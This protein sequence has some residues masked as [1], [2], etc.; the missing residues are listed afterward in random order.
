MMLELKNIS[1][2][3]SDF[4]LEDVSFQLGNSEYHMLLGPSGAGK[5]LVM[6]IIA[7]FQKPDSGNILYLSQDITNTEPRSRR[8]SY[9]IQDLALFPHLTVWENVA[10]PLS[11]SGLKK[12]EISHRVKKYLDFTE[13][14]HLSDRQINGLSGGEKQ[15]VA[16]AR[17][18]I[19]ETRLI[20]LDEPFSAL[21]TQLRMS[22]KKLLKKIS[23][24]GVSV[25]HITHNLDEAVNLADRITVIENGRIISSGKT[26]EVLK[27]KSSRFMAS[28]SGEK[29]FFF[30]VYQKTS[31]TARFVEMT[32]DDQDRENTFKVEFSGTIPEN[33]RAVIIDSRS[34]VLSGSRI[35]SSARNNFQAVISALFRNS[36][37]YDVELFIAFNPDIG[38]GIHLWT[39]ITEQSYEEMGLGIDKPVWLSFK[40]SAVRI[41]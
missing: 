32:S 12:N 36:S 16:L 41:I 5:T 2:R 19:T 34:I 40:A 26:R 8:I 15:R 14:A 29:N 13:T 7:G 3:F 18:L 17:I 27:K 23:D 22:L 20:M 10:F 35:L 28:F 6:N 11:V 9:L 37:G 30:F 33:P 38:K 31:G 25:L 21:D 1:L 4:S 24:T 39:S